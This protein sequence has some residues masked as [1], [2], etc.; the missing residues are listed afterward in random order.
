MRIMDKRYV[1]LVEDN[2]DEVVLTQLAFKKNQIPARLEVAR[3]GREALD[4][5]FCRGKYAVRDPQDQP[6]LVLL[7]LKLPLIS[8]LEVLQQIRA[9]KSTSE[10]SVV[11]L[12]CS[13]EDI[14][15]AESYRLGANGFIRK[16]TR[17]SEFV[18]AI[19]TIHAKWLDS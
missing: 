14:D 15:Q 16:P 12:T 18:E 6:A 2:S 4:F 13:T 17:F 5:L 10:I 8:G 19:R 9:A 7:D 3:D 11:V 1:L